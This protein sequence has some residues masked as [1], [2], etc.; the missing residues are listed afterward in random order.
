MP[1]YWAQKFYCEYA[2]KVFTA[3]LL[4]SKTYP[5]CGIYNRNYKIIVSLLSQSPPS[6]GALKSPTSPTTTDPAR[7]TIRPRSRSATPEK[8]KPP[9]TH[10]KPKVP[11]PKPPRVKPRT[12][13]GGAH[14]SGDQREG[15]TPTPPTA[16]DDAPSSEQPPPTAKKVEKA[17]DN[18]EQESTKDGPAAVETEAP[19]EQQQQQQLVGEE[20]KVGN[21]T[22]IE[23]CHLKSVNISIFDLS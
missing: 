4:P 7:E 22:M 10:S 21:C 18:Q 13:V 19:A 1:F 12:H 20:A 8:P 3:K 14:L 16:R 11:P 6:P 9:P 2:W 23:F 15:Q 5:L 17:P